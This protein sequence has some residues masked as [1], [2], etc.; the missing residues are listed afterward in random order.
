VTERTQTVTTFDGDPSAGEAVDVDETAQAQ[1][2]D[3][4]AAAEVT[5]AT[6][7]EAAD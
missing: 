7:D 1:A 3:T 2:T 6:A 4:S 5:E